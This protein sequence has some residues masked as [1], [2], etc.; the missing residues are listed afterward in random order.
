MKKIILSFLFFVSIQVH[1]VDTLKMSTTTSTENSGL[2]AVLHPVFEKKY[3]AR[4]DVIAVGTG[5]ALKL[6]ENGDVDLVFVHAPAAEIAFVEAGYG[7]DR[8]AV[9]HND[10]VILGA[11]TDSAT[12]KSSKTAGEAL[13]KIAESKSTFISRGDD[14]GTH[15][16]ENSLWKIAN[17]S[18]KGDWY[19]AVGQGMGAVLKIADEKQAY[20]LTDRGTYLAYQD[21]IDLN[22]VFEGDKFLFNPYHVI[23]VN[24]ALHKTANYSLAKK[25][26]AFIT[27]EEGQNMIARYKKKEQQ[28]FTPDALSTKK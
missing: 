8:Q 17:V 6:A 27:S 14:S 15:K 10:F 16:K 22:I 4:I 24:P 25:Y 2:L 21:K 18:P 23:A 9:M 13:R 3:Q 26:I 11:K 20:T 7:I 19:L 1:A 5:K 28:L 12:L